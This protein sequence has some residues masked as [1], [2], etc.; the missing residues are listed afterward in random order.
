MNIRILYAEND[1]VFLETRRA[2]LHRQGWEV[3][4]AHSF[5]EAVAKMR[6]GYFDL[7][8]FD[9]RLGNDD[10][11]HDRQ[12]LQ[13]AEMEEFSPL[14][15]IIVTVYASIEAT[16]SMFRSRRPSAPVDYLRK[17]DGVEEMIRAIEKVLEECSLNS[18]LRIEYGDLPL[19]GLAEMLAEHAPKL[20][21]EWHV[22][23]VEAL[24]RRLFPQAG[25]LRLERTLWR[26]DGLIAVLVY[27]SS[28]AGDSESRVI[29]CGQREAIA[30]ESK[31]YET[32]A[33]KTPRRSSTLKQAHQETV[34][35]AA[36]AYALVG[37]GAGRILNLKEAYSQSSESQF[38][39]VVQSL[40]SG[41]LRDW[42][43]NRF[44]NDEQRTLDQIYRELTLPEPVRSSPQS[45]AE[46]LKTLLPR[47]P[48]GKFSITRE[49]GK[50]QFRLNA[51]A[52]SPACADPF[53][54]IYQPLPRKD[55]VQ[56]IHSPVRLTG[57]NILTDGQQ[58]WLTDFSA[59][60]YAPA[61]WNFLELEAAIRFDWAETQDLG[62]LHELEQILAGN[63]FSLPLN[64]LDN[65]LRKPVK[66][67]QAI[68]QLAQ[69]ESDDWSLYHFGLLFQIMRRL[70]I[71]PSHQERSVEET[72]RLAHL[73]MAAGLTCHHLATG[74]GGVKPRLWFDERTRTFY[75]FGQPLDNLTPQNRDLL[76]YLYN[77]RDRFCDHQELRENA[78]DQRYG[79]DNTVVQAIKRL[80]E[81]IHAEDLDPPL[82]LSRMDGY[83]LNC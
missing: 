64:R 55:A 4:P 21:P 63:D 18:Q 25:R 75:L 10:D 15:R 70:A 69:L 7:A 53:E 67:I 20:A 33:P 42:Q 66:A 68:R 82:I 16:R 72:A 54:L 73:L 34:Q 65:T 36:N 79:K 27:E 44:K 77:H 30:R 49:D 57:Q 23:S 5:P 38:A 26:G 29:L 47:I 11:E 48:A 32:A 13:L 14:P 62:K 39:L 43:A 1:K 71:R 50:F 59:A 8:V 61:H 45:L 12:G 83:K 52:P 51:H 76:A 6:A 37:A 17:E 60:D 22:A 24:L 46:K 2:H 28:D 74:D 41:T 40:F 9:Q 58:T 78:L 81:R 19:G 35:F 56:L 3:E 31:Q 80:L